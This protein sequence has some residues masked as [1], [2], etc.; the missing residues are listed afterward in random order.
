VG[1]ELTRESYRKYANCP[2]NSVDFSKVRSEYFACI[3]QLFTD[4]GTYMHSDV[5]LY[6]AEKILEDGGKLKG[7]FW[8]R[9]HLVA[10]A[11]EYVEAFQRLNETIDYREEI[12]LEGAVIDLQTAH[13]AF[14]VQFKRELGTVEKIRRKVRGV[15]D[16]LAASI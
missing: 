9:L 2:R 13:Y 14:A 8:S 16:Y 6:H 5:F 10:P 3:N 12:F 15:I 1:I 4:P 11:K 7:D